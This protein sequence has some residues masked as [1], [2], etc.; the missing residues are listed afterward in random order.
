MFLSN[1]LVQLIM[2]GYYS[3]LTMTSSEIKKIIKF[4]VNKKKIFL[5]KNLFIFVFNWTYCRNTLKMYVLMVFQIVFNDLFSF[6]WYFKKR[7]TRRDSVTKFSIFF[8]QLFSFRP[9]ANDA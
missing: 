9:Y 5:M 1:S 6:R 2:D 8:N 4:G 7:D 3:H